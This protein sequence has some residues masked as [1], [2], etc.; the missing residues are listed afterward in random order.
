[1]NEEENTCDTVATPAPPPP[2]LLVELNDRAGDVLRQLFFRGPTW[3]G[4]VSSKSGRDDLIRYGLAT[5]HEG[6]QQLTAAG[7]KVAL[8]NGL[9]RAKERK[10][11]ELSAALAAYRSA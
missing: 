9:G 2:A 5:A 8:A 6:Y 11:R 1:M 4:D 7:L 10:D 3:D